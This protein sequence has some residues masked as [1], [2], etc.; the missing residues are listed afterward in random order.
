MFF[1]D[2]VGPRTDLHA[3]RG[4][5]ILRD[6][7]LVGLCLMD[8]NGFGLMS[9]ARS[10]LGAAEIT[11]SIT[12]IGNRTLRGAP[13]AV[14]AP[15]LTTLPADVEPDPLLALHALR[16]SLRA[17]PG[18]DPAP[19]A[20]I[21]ENPHHL[22]PASAGL[23]A[24]I[25]TEPGVRLLM[26]C[27]SVSQLPAEF[28]GLLAEGLIE[29]LALSGLNYAEVEALA[30]EALH[31]IT[32]W[33]LIN[34]LSRIS[35]GNP[36]ILRR[37]LE[38]STGNGALACQDGVWLFRSPPRL[39]SL[40]RLEMRSRLVDQEPQ[41]RDALYAVALAHA[42]P[43][44]TLVDLFGAVPVR[45]LRAS[46]ILSVDPGDTAARLLRVRPGI[47][48]DLLREIITPA[49]SRVLW[50]RVFPALPEPR[51]PEAIR[52][53]ILWTI[54]CGGTPENAVLLNLAI[55]ANHINRPELALD[56]IAR[57]QGEDL[58][59]GLELQRARAHF[60]RGEVSTAL[61]TLRLTLTRGIN[62]KDGQR[63]MSLLAQIYFITGQ[64]SEDLFPALSEWQQASDRED[65]Q[66]QS[67][68][69]RRAEAILVPLLTMARGAYRD[70][71]AEIPPRRPEAEP[72]HEE[73]LLLDL[74]EGEILASLGDFDPGITKLRHAFDTMRSRD[75]LANYGGY[76]YARLAIFLT[77][78]ARWDEL[79][80]LHAEP[81]PWIEGLGGLVELTRAVQALQHG[82]TPRAQEHARAG[83]VLTRISDSQRVR[84]MTLSFAAFL[85]VHAGDSALGAAYIAELDSLD[86]PGTPLLDGLARAYAAYAREGEP[87][88]IRVNAL[89]E[90][91]RSSAA[92]GPRAA[93]VQALILLLR[94]EADGALEALH[95][96]TATASDPVGIASHAL[97]TALLARDPHASLRAA[98]VALEY[99]LDY[100]AAGALG[101]C[102]L[103]LRATP[104]RHLQ[105]RALT[106]LARVE[107]AALAL[108]TMLGTARARALLTAREAEVARFIA[109]GMSS[110]EVARELSLSD[111]TVDGH[112]QRILE[113]LGLDSRASLRA[114]PDEPIRSPEPA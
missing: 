104:D 80:R 73:D 17:E 55:L 25:A 41:Q 15:Y 47:T 109:R 65:D 11:R 90:I 31:G 112:V 6:P 14:L 92:N 103:R 44:A 5:E 19:A 63:A 2:S 45:A 4:A 75:N 99:R 52:R 8:S 7:G 28:R 49:Q 105:R 34:D 18:A 22:D 21:V 27:R 107:P 67:E 98:E 16:L 13:L 58:A 53:Y 81:A 70:A 87:E 54:E 64:G 77:Y 37:V 96:A 59:I 72:I 24:R 69:S 43:E 83:V 51:G 20:I 82:D 35:G 66:Q 48:A 57:R 56:A 12:V 74:V 95:E 78:G 26:L 38:E 91:A 61:Y 32:P 93:Q 76:V 71:L 85:A 101:D 108:D 29:L 94:M 60:G 89:W 97:T 88:A 36:E 30:R 50:E 86:Y 42:I 110:R 33:T 10:V 79:A 114:E 68:Y 40:T 3:R 9:A 62:A 106:L 102:F 113:K 46:E 23:L 111:R 100:I 84:P 39:D 1:P